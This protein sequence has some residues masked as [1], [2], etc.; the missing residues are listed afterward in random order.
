MRLRLASKTPTVGELVSKLHAV[1]GKDMKLSFEGKELPSNLRSYLHRVGAVSGCVLDCVADSS[2]RPQ[3]E[4]DEQGVELKELCDNTPATERK[5][6][7]KK[8][9]R[10][11]LPVGH[12]KDRCWSGSSRF[13]AA[14]L[15]A[16]RHSFMS[17]RNML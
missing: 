5:S 16:T 4:Q 1:T 13:V 15:L 6:P 3:I 8:R 9:T 11:L 10:L 17:T 2:T 12:G 14:P 7:S